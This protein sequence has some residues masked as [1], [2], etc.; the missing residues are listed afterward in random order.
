MRKKKKKKNQKIRNEM[1]DQKMRKMW[2]EGFCG[3][4]ELLGKKMVKW[5]NQIVWKELSDPTT[6]QP[7]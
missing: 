4:N 7:N 6:F 3:W 1:D 2:D 5:L